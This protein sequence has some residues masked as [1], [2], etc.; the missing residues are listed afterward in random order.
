MTRGNNPVTIR[1]ANNRFQRFYEAFLSTLGSQKTAQNG[2]FSWFLII[3]LTIESIFNQNV[4]VFK[5]HMM[6]RVQVFDKIIRPDLL[7]LVW[8]LKFHQ[9]D[10]YE[11][12]FGF[13]RFDESY[14]IPF[15]Q[16]TAKKSKLLNSMLLKGSCFFSRGRVFFLPKLTKVRSALEP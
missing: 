5:S 15:F 7:P 16:K 2:Y 1:L 12:Y 8:S 3:Y 10:V 14:F 9:Q 13:W 4:Y 6:P 11:T